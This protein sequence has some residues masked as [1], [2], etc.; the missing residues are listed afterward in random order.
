MKERL[1]KVVRWA[2]IACAWIFV[3]SI[4]VNGKTLFYYGNDILVQNRVVQAI[5]SQVTDWWQQ[6]KVAART[7][8]ADDVPRKFFSR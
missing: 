3:L 6:A 7:A 8:L 2:V 1:F 4:K 5:D